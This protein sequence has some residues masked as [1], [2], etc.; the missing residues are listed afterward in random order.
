MLSKGK[1]DGGLGLGGL[2]FQNEALFA[3]WGWRFMHEREALWRKMV[4]SIHDISNLG[5]HSTRK[6][7][8]SLRSPWMSISKIW[9]S[10]GPKVHFIVGNGSRL[11][12][13]CSIWA[14]KVGVEIPLPLTS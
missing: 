5:W 10:M 2:K 11:S 1:E 8:L 14:K 7:P 6:N 13:W 3:K 4:A 9:L 12:F